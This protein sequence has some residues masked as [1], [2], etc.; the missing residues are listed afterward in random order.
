MV[1]LVKIVDLRRP[2]SFRILPFHGVHCSVYLCVSLPL[3]AATSHA[4]GND[5]LVLFYLN[6]PSRQAPVIRPT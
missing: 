6:H 5:D 1:N 2:F 4:R 3:L